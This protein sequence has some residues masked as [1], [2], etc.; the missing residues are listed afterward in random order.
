MGKIVGHAFKHSHFVYGKGP[1]LYYF[2]KGTG[3]VES[4]K[5]QFLLTFSTNYAD[6]GW[7]GGSEKVKKCADVI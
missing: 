6:G 4:E 3:W 7:V 2:S 1:T 5:W